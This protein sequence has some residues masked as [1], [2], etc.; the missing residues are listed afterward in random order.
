MKDDASATLIT[1]MISLVFLLSAAGLAI[2]LAK[3]QLMLST[4][5]ERAQSAADSAITTVDAS[6]SLTAES[7]KQFNNVYNSK[8]GSS[9]FQVDEGNAYKSVECN[10]KNR[11]IPSY[12]N[13]NSKMT[14]R[15]PAIVMQLNTSRGSTSTTGIN[16]LKNSVDPIYFGQN[17]NDPTLVRGSYNVNKK[18][19]VFDARV[20]DTRSN[21]FLGM[22]GYPCQNFTMEVGSISFGNKAD[23]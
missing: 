21:L 19:T 5:T 11:S 18:Y 6:G 15:T 20:H 3:N 16:P 17:G 22:V 23:G 13:P 10:S 9:T 1:I 8:G 7:V 4:L 2:D 14:V 12:A